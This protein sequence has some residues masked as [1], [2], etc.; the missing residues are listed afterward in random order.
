MQLYHFQQWCSS[1]KVS[2]EAPGRVLDFSL[3]RENPYE[4][5]D[6]EVHA[7]GQQGLNVALVDA[8]PLVHTVQDDA[9]SLEESGVNQ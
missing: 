2:G 8:G 3:S 4:D 6:V 1:D 9:E 5:P 7:D